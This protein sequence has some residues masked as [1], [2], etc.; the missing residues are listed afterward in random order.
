[1][2]RFVAVSASQLKRV[3]LGTPSL[4][5]ME[6]KLQPLARKTIKR[7]LVSFFS[8]SLSSCW[9]AGAGASLGL[10]GFGRFT[11]NGT[12]G[13]VG[14]CEDATMGGLEDAT[15]EFTIFAGAD[16]EPSRAMTA[17]EGTVW[18]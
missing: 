4:L 12:D 1:M 17:S 11:G 9:G 8:S 15:K 3:D 16:S 14:G 18:A 5:E 6:R 13:K 7:S 2:A 10:G